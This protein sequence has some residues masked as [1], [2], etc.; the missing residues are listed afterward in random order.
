M[1][2]LHGHGCIREGVIIKEK[3]SALLT[4]V[5]SI[6]VLILISSVLYTFAISHTKVETS[7]EKG[8][9]A[10]HLAEAGIQYGIAKVWDLELGQEDFPMDI[11]LD[12]PFGQD[13]RIFIEL[14][15]P[16]HE[17]DE[18]VNFFIVRSTA[19]YNDIT[20]IKEAGYLYDFVVDE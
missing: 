19:T 15:L 4:S 6:L 9:I 17:E 7:E 11:T 16:E 13:G 12:K 18:I 5:I 20:R 10:Y 14:S 1:N 2:F 3:G 8:L